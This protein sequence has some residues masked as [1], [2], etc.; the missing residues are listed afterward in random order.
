MITLVTL[1]HVTSCVLLILIVLLQVG[2]GADLGSTF[3]G[4]SQSV[5]GSGGAA[6]FLTKL[7]TFVA[8]VFMITSLSLTMISSREAKKTVVDSISAPAV[9]TPSAPQAPETKTPEIPVQPQK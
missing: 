5:F 8:I 4:G 2:K 6:P 1:F 9:P 3:G 7:T